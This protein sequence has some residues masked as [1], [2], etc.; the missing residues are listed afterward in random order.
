[1][2]KVTKNQ[3]RQNQS[4]NFKNLIIENVFLRLMLSSLAGIFIKLNN[5]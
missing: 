5:F 3:R 4:E 1:M 2:E